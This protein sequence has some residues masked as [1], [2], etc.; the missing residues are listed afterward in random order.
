MFNRHEFTKGL[1]GA[2]LE[3]AITPTVYLLGRSL[4]RFADRRGR[5][6]PSLATLAESVGCSVRTVSRAI[7]QLAD[8]G[9]LSW[10][11]RHGTRY[12]RASNLYA[13]GARQKTREKPLESSSAKMSN[14]PLPDRVRQALER[15]GRVM[16]CPP[17]RV[18]P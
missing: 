13:L 8:L 18:M 6:W 5:A 15:L 1:W 3:G 9:L 16:G 2:R 7:D 14:G 10:T 11:Q 4:L 12:R 17:E